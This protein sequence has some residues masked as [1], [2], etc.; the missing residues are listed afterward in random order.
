MTEQEMYLFD[1]QGYLTVPNALNAAQLAALNALLDEH[2]A[3]EAEQDAPSHRFVGLL[4]WG[5]PYRDLIDNSTLVPYLET[6]L[7]AN[8]RLDHDYADVIR[9]GKGPIGTTL[10]G[11]S[12]PHNPGQF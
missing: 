7:G 2:L 8:F 10:H 4:G 5:K 3:Q 11:G 1:L 12:T 9:T 6:L